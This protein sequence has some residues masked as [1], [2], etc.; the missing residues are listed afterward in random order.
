[1]TITVTVKHRD[2]SSVQATIWASTEVKFERHFQTS[3]S[4][5]FTEEHPR[6]EYLYFAAFDALSEAGKTGLTFDEWLKTIGEVSVEALD[7]HPTDP[8][9]SPGS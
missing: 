5:A 3:W 8:E 2:G 7:S 1:M 4:E 9:A 6:Q